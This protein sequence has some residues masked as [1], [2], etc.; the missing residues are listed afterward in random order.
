MLEPHEALRSWQQVSSGSPR[1]APDA[2]LINRTY[3]V[4]DPPTAVL[5]WVN[6]IFD[7]SIHH[8]IAALTEHLA[9]SGLDTPKLLPT[10]EGALSLD[11]SEGSWRLLS[12]VPGRTV[13]RLDGPELAFEAGRLVGR[14]HAAVADWDHRFVAPR[15]NIHDTPARMAELESALDAAENHPLADDVRRI[16][17]EIL[18]AWRAWDGSLDQPERPCH[19]DLKISNLRFDADGRGLCLIDLDT[20][21]PMSIAAEMGDAWRSWCNPV[22]EDQPDSASFDLDRFRASARGWLSTAPPL[23]DSERIALVPAIERIALELAARFAADA[24]RNSYFWEDRE[25]FSQP[26]QHNLMRCRGQLAF[27]RSAHAQRS[28]AEEATR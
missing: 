20:I 15:R 12:Y 5:Q 16:G 23:T 17:D 8:D 27:A 6:P 7:A 2:G 4:G 1:P 21:G 11:D 10:R 22:P 18:T 26:G 28:Q 13:H 14:F 24:L 19:G 25:R 3:L 9:A